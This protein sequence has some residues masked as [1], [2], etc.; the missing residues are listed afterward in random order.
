MPPQDAHDCDVHPSITPASCF[1]LAVPSISGCRSTTHDESGQAMAD[2]VVPHFHNNP[3]VAVIEIGT[4][5]FMC[6][7]AIPPFDHPH[8]FIDMG[9]ASEIICPYCSTLYRYDPGLDAFTA[10]PPECGLTD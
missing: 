10:R 6:V 5:E 7:G 2:H 8:E 3:G 9:D 4:R 1:H